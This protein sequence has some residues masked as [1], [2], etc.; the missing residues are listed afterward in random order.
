MPQLATKISTRRSHYKR[1]YGIPLWEVQNMLDA[2]ENKCAIC[3]RQTA[4]IGQGRDGLN[5]DHNHS[6]G[7]TRGMICSGCNRGL[8]YFYEN[9]EALRK[10][11]EYLEKYS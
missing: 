11:A 7:A 2:Q 3:N 8:G 9:P 6:T 5:L 10:A 1:N 4:G